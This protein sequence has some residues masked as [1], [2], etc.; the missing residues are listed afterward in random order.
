MST[1][2]IKRFDL[3][4]GL[5]CFACGCAFLICV[6]TKIPN[7]TASIEDIIGFICLLMYIAMLFYMSINLFIKYGMERGIDYAIEK[8]KSMP[9][10]DA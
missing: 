5:I 1:D 10:K 4:C 6:S 8:Q 2:S 3:I 7:L 9:M